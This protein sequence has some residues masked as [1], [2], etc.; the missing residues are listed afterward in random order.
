MSEQ[1]LVAA[2]TTCLDKGVLTVTLNRPQA[3]NALSLQMVEELSRVFDELDGDVRVVIIRGAGGNFCAG[4]DVKDM[5]GLLQGGDLDA[6]AAYSASAG[7]MLQKVYRSKAAVIAAAEGAVMGGGFGLTCAADIVIATEDAKFG[8]P[9]TS[10]GLVPAQIAPYVVKR[11][12]RSYARMLAV[13]GGVIE[14][15]R[16]QQIGLVHYVVENERVLDE[17]ISEITSRVMNCAPNALS[18]SKELVDAREA[19][20]VDDPEKLGNIFARAMLG[21]EAAEGI[22]AFAEKRKPQWVQ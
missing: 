13:S 21:A 7:R 22:A 3:R 4:G 5:A 17:L 20:D 18:V 19:S 14:A 6:V 10:L 11:V 9:E 16:A 12:G 15:R 2:I 1:T 8:L